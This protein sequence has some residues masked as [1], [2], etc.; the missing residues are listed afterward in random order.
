MNFFG[1]LL[2]H[3]TQAKVFV[4]AA[5]EGLKIEGLAP[6]PEF[7][8]GFTPTQLLAAAWFTRLEQ[9]LDSRTGYSP[10]NPAVFDE[11][12]GGTATYFFTVNGLRISY[13]VF[14]AARKTLSP[15]DQAKLVELA[16]NKASPDLR[17]IFKLWVAFCVELSKYQAR[18]KEGWI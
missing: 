1:F 15:S 14:E 18:T 4:V 6:V 12:K 17:I 11:P 3:P 13:A 5:P 16:Q 2:E 8:T 7:N 10:S 9:G